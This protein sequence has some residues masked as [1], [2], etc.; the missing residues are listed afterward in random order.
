VDDH[1]DP[2]AE[3]ARLLEVAAERYLHVAAIMPAEARFSG[4]P[5]RTA[6]DA[7]IAEAE[8]RRNGATRSLA[9]GPKENA[10]K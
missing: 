3:L 5:D 4:Q 10:S 9:S 7:A 8:L 1:G 2:M 6:V